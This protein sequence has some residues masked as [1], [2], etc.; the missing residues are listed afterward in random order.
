[1]LDSLRYTRALLQVMQDGRLS[2]SRLERLAQKRLKRVLTSAYLH[3]PYY[4]ET[5][6]AV[7]YNPLRDYRGPED[8]QGLPVISRQVLKTEGR[9]AFVK[10]GIDLSNCARDITS[11]STGVPLVVYQSKYEHAVQAAKWLRVLFVNGYT[12]REKVMSLSILSKYP[13]QSTMIERFGPLERLA[14]SLRLPPEKIVDLLLDYRPE[15][16]YGAR[17]LLDLIALELMRRGVQPK[18]LKLVIGAAE[19]I[20]AGSRR[21]CRQIFGTEMLEVYGSVEMGGNIAYETGAHD[22]LHLCEDLIYFEFLDEEGEP[23]P[24]GK[25]G[26]VVLT[27]LT[28]DVMPFIRYDQGDWAVFEREGVHRN[29]RR[30]ITRIL[31]R[32]CDL[33]QLPDGTQRSFHSFAD[34]MHEND[35]ILQFRV[36]QKTPSLFHILVVAAPSYLLQIEEDL[37]GRLQAR[38]PNTVRFEIIPVDRIEPD[39]S[40]KLRWLISEVEATEKKDS[41]S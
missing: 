11:G 27:D 25:P 16:L 28:G 14:V 6:Q 9:A 26:K 18:P 20:G 30:R 19:A 35:R 36:V 7:G 3:V 10:E 5:M 39:P 32:D 1:M 2:P 31:G 41:G 40:G 8:L 17:T 33:V 21:L 24:P 34:I 12:G 13:G 4:R 22:G 38:F 37:M 23:V 15:V 29:G